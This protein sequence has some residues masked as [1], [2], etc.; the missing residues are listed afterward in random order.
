[1]ASPPAAYPLRQQ[2][3]RASRQFTLRVFLLL[4]LIGGVA[5][6][7]WFAPWSRHVANVR[8]EVAP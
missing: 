2:R 5:Y 7:A 8:I 3:Q 6:A 1:M 4:T